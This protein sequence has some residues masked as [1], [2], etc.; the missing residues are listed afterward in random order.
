MYESLKYLD[1]MVH[2]KILMHEMFKVMRLLRDKTN[3]LAL[4]SLPRHPNGVKF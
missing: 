4:C 1:R 2:G 3:A